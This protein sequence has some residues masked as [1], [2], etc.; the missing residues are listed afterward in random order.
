MVEPETEL[1]IPVDITQPL[2]DL[3][4]A[5][6]PAFPNVDQDPADTGTAIPLEEVPEGGIPLDTSELPPAPV[7][8]LP[9]DVDTRARKIAF[10]LGKQRIPIPELKQKLQEGL[11]TSLRAELADKETQQYRAAKDEIIRQIAERKGTN[12]STEE[13]EIVHSL[14][15]EDLRANPA[16]ILEKKFSEAVLVDLWEKNR[17]VFGKNYVP[18]PTEESVY[19]NTYG[20]TFT[21][22]LL[23]TRLAAVNAK[24]KQQ[25]YG[26]DVSDLGEALVPLW[27][28]QRQWSAMKDR[29][30]TLRDVFAGETIEQNVQWFWAQTPETQQKLLDYAIPY[31]EKNSLHEARDFLSSLIWY[32]AG[33]RTVM[34]VISALDW[35]LVVGLARRIGSRLRNRFLGAPADAALAA[36]PNVAATPSNP[37]VVSPKEI[38]SNQLVR[39]GD[40]FDL[41]AVEEALGHTSHRVPFQGELPLNNRAVQNAPPGPVTPTGLYRGA[42]GRFGRATNR[43]ESFLIKD[44]VEEASGRDILGA[45]ELGFSRPRP[46]VNPLGIYRDPRT[47]RMQR[48]TGA[49][50]Q[51]DLDFGPQ[52]TLPLP[53]PPSFVDRGPRGDILPPG[54]PAFKPDPSRLPKAPLGDVQTARQKALLAKLKAQ[55]KGPRGDILELSAIEQSLKRVVTDPARGPKAVAADQERHTLVAAVHTVVANATPGLTVRQ[56]ENQLGNARTAQVLGA[57]EQLTV[58]QSGRNPTANEMMA[59]YPSLANMNA[60]VKGTT[61]LDTVVA[62]KMAARMEAKG[63]ELVDRFLNAIK[64]GRLTDS[65][66][67]AGYAD[68]MRSL[69]AEVNGK[70]SILDWRGEAPKPG[71]TVNLHSVVAVVGDTTLKEFPKIERAA[72]TRDVLGLPDAKIV[73]QGNGYVLEISRHVPEN[74][75]SVRAGMIV[76]ENLSKQSKFNT[77]LDMLPAGIG[78]MIRSPAQRISKMAEGIR[79]AATHSPQELNRE[80]SKLVADNLQTLSKTEQADFIDIL[81]T[82]QSWVTEAR[83]D[84]PGKWFTTPELEEQYFLRHKRVPTE[85]EIEAY[86]TFVQLHDIEHL[87]RKHS[88]MRD[89]GRLG[90]EE[91]RL[92]TPTEKSEWFKGIVIDRDIFKETAEHKKFDAGV[93]AY[94]SR[95]GQGSFHSLSN[96]PKDVETALREQIAAG[97]RVVQLFPGDNALK[98]IAKTAEGEN[99]KA[100]IHYLITDGV[101]RRPLNID[102]LIDYRPGGHTIYDSGF[103]IGQ[104]VFREGRGGNR[105]L[106]SDT[107]RLHVPTEAQAKKWAGRMDEANK[108]LAAGKTAELTAFLERSLPYSLEQFV[109]LKLDPTQPVLYKALNH[110]ILET[111]P[112]L[113]RGMQDVVEERFNPHNLEGHID[114]R[115]LQERD[116]T[117]QTIREGENGIL[118]LHPAGV[119]DPYES[120]NIAM[121]QAVHNVWMQDAKI[122]GIE[123]WI[124]EFR[125]VLNVSPQALAAHPSYYIHGQHYINTADKT[126]VAAAESSRRQLLAFLGQKNATDTAVDTFKS[127]LLDRIYE[128]SGAKGLEDYEFRKNKLDDWGLGAIKDPVQFLKAAAFYSSMA[129]WNPSHYL[130]QGTTLATISAIVGPKIGYKGLIGSHYGK[131]YDMNPAHLDFLA[132]QAASHGWDAKQFKEMATM[133]RDSG[134]MRVGEKYAGLD[135]DSATYFSTTAGTWLDKSTFFFKRME[136]TVHRMAYAAAYQEFRAA[137]PLRTIDLNDAGRIG[138]RARTLAGDMTA[139][140]QAGWQKGILGIPSQFFTFF[141]RQVEQVWGNTLTRAEKARMLGMYGLLYGVPAAVTVPFLGA[142]PLG[143]IGI[144]SSYDDISIAAKRNGWD[145][146]STSIKALHGGLVQMSLAAVLGRE[147]N[148]AQAFGPGGGPLGTLQSG[149]A[150]LWGALGGVSGSLLGSLVEAAHPLLYWTRAAFYGGSESIAYSMT[151]TDMLN[152]ARSIRTVDK[153]VK[154]YMAGNYGLWVARSGKVTA[155]NADGLDAF[156]TILGLTRTEYTQLYDTQKAIKQ[157]ETYKDRFEKDA[158]TQYNA[159]FLEFKIGNYDAG[160]VHMKNVAAIMVLSGMNPKDIFELTKRGMISK[161]NLSE[162]IAWD[163]LRKSLNTEYEAINNQYNKKK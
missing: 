69:R 9:K 86:H 146:D 161:G 138:S 59:Q 67:L 44:G 47:G 62:T 50:R 74:V 153:A 103:F 92:V 68:V 49:Y 1:P 66:A 118:N 37:V 15:N 4:N 2:P 93:Y 16:A 32:G 76:P 140:A 33:D 39:Q 70:A 111:H 25:S 58:K 6:A 99:V 42:G 65:A 134:F 98:G 11:E 22:E 54:G 159:A 35:T 41:S 122:H 112:H 79:F 128:K 132:N 110:S 88:A 29:P 145:M 144:P 64:I 78:W 123:T 8:P 77:I 52:A 163:N 158:M 81:R 130:L 155:D 71:D 87:I 97:G 83:P 28:H 89:F 53:H 127:K 121:R 84:K 135:I 137:Y 114:R 57:E 75:D 30:S 61:S 20:I 26:K 3:L 143:W 131:L 141:I 91:I 156:L 120:M 157:R 152:G 80:I 40:L 21:H 133:L 105:V 14:T 85:K 117:L 17:Q 24:I 154:A 7:P 34:N 12:L 72:F 102:N 18:T 36:K 94:D 38:G 107:L 108:L 27:T 124:Q 13:L 150:S 147:Y 31:L 63:K 109:A 142:S 100:S 43:T 149:D 113:K 101:E 51:T 96:I 126:L 45:Y 82:G 119:L 106:D 73:Q 139:D 46:E 151:T 23:S 10:S 129:F 5:P 136:E 55:G 48:D 104:M 148:V 162:T 115:F 160:H 116:I 95:T 125:D 19:A 60:V 56:I 90:T